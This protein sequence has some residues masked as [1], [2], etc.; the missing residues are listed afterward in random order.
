MNCSQWGEKGATGI[1]GESVHLTLIHSFKDYLLSTCYLLE[2]LGHTEMSRTESS[3]LEAGSLNGRT[4]IL[5]WTGRRL[6]SCSDFHTPALLGL[7]MESVTVSLLWEALWKPGSLPSPK[8]KRPAWPVGRW[9]G[10]EDGVRASSD[11]RATPLCAHSAH[12]G[13]S[14]SPKL[15]K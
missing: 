5:A 13:S 9:G 3:S 8:S 6:N 10:L 2:P 12:M 11:T 15:L 4:V 7:H 1:R 14:A